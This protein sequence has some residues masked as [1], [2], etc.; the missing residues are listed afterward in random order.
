MRGNWEGIR[1]Y[2]Y[3]HVLSERQSQLYPNFPFTLRWRR[4]YCRMVQGK[5]EKVFYAVNWS[6]QMK[7]S[8][9]AEDDWIWWPVK[10]PMCTAWSNPIVCGLHS[11]A[12][13]HS[14]GSWF[15]FVDVKCLLNVF[16]STMIVSWYSDGN[17]MVQNPNKKYH[18]FFN[19]FMR[20][21]Q[22]MIPWF[23]QHGNVVS[24]CSWKYFGV[25]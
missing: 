2:A 5:Q 7:M 9:I 12:V 15:W 13:S 25:P 3:T 24:C 23:F 22:M 18:C 11:F 19:F 14:H 17:T 20:P 6:V 4:Y 21:Y 16:T 8:A 1:L 10:V